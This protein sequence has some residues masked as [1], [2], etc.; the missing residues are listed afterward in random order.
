MALKLS[1]S[2]SFPFRSRNH[3]YG[4]FL[5]PFF[6]N[7]WFSSEWSNIQKMITHQRDNIFIEF[8]A[9]SSMLDPI[10][11]IGAAGGDL[12]QSSLEAYVTDIYIF[13]MSGFLAN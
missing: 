4:E 10:S 5:G 2:A 3:H 1:G 12:I 11:K 13:Q 7:S 9:F 8:D 6:D